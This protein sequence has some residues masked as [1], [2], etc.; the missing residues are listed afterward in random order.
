MQILCRHC[1]KTLLLPADGALPPR[2]PHCHAAPGPGTLGA[3]EPVRLLAA[4]GMGE[5]YLARHREL[6]TEVAIKLLRPMPL[7][8]LP[9]LRERFAR[10]ARLAARVAHPGVV[11]VLASELA[12]DRPFLV[13]ELVRGR[14]LRALLAEGPPTIAEALRLAIATAEVLA[15]AH[16]HGVLHRDVKPDNVMVQDDG[17]VRVLDFGIA[18]AI[19]DDA[20]L[21][22]TGELVGTPEYM[23][24]EQLLDGP[25]AVDART[26][27]H[28]LGVLTYELLTGRSPFRGSSLFQTLKLVESLTPP[29]PSSLREQVPAEV[30]AV[31]RRALHKEPHA[32]PADAGSFAAALRTAQPKPASDGGAVRRRRQLLATGLA[33]LVGG[34]LGSIGWRSPPPVVPVVVPPSSAQLRAGERAEIAQD[35]AGGRWLRALHRAE[36][37]VAAGDAA[38]MELA[39][40][41]FV[42]HHTVWPQ[43]LGLPGWLGACDEAQR[44]R[45]FVD[46][47][48]LAT[49]PAAEPSPRRGSASDTTLRS[50][51]VAPGR[52]DEARIGVLQ[53][54]AQRLPID[55]A[56]HWL[57][58]LAVRH[59][60]GDALGRE[61][62]AEQAWLHGAGELAVLLDA[63]AAVLPRG[64]APAAL[65]RPVGDARALRWRRR[66]LAAVGDDAPAAVLLHST[67]AA[68]GDETPQLQALRAVPRRVAD[69]VAPWFVGLAAADS[70]ARDQLL[71]ASVVLGSRPDYAAAPWSAVDPE[72]RRVLDAEVQRGR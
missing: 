49:A 59:L 29:Q 68:L 4:G 30:D 33:L 58:Q 2:C 32:R 13:L 41:A 31:L 71:L 44:R 47:V 12:D 7:E 52:G 8:Q 57:A 19:A 39:R 5:V 38:A 28:A 1:N 6:G 26:D 45:L 56:E 34:T 15:E 22:R 35:L 24:P 55:E 18:R 37:L 53:G 23:A 62:A 36:R 43:V 60:R 72:R 64:D 65:V 54:H 40:E 69:Q 11:R 50:L 67:L 25:E 66:V 51:L 46:D 3:Y 70:A 61:Q 63:G 27:V 42:L 21:T 16:A 17:R 20:P 48:E 14:T 10:E 9:G